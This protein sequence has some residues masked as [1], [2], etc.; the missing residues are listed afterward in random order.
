MPI[1]NSN[2]TPNT[3]ESASLPSLSFTPIIRC[4]GVLVLIFGLWAAY[5]VMQEA[6][7]LYDNPKHVT[8]LAQTIA[9]DSEID[10][11][12]NSLAK[13]MDEAYANTMSNLPT[14]PGKEPIKPTAKIVPV[15]FS[16]FVSWGIIIILLFLLAKIGYWAIVAG[17]KLAMHNEDQKEFIAEIIA[18]IIAIKGS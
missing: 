18:K 11:F 14:Q 1:M 2:P 3:S 16:Y 8:T 13:M 9:T 15:K 4:L 7:Y 17:G 12:S 10:Q 5:R 6:W